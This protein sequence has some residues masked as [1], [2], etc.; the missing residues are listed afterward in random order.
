MTGAE[1]PT[2]PSSSGATGARPRRRDLVGA[3]LAGA[4]VVLLL[5]SEAALALPGENDPDS[6]VASFY[7]QHRS[8]VVVLQL[9][10]LVA[11]ALLAGYSARLRRF[12]TVAGTVGLITA[13]LACAP[14]VVTLVIALVADPAHPG[15]AGTW[16]TREPRGDD[17]LFVGITLF[18]AAVAARPRFP[19][20]AR[21]LGAIVAVLCGARLLLEWTGHPRGTFESLGPIAFVVLVACLGG[22]SATGRLAPTAS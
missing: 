19:A 9:I 22:F 2:A 14:A 17:L 18:G 21:V 7:Q 4:F 10:G 15:A 12:D 11:A 1:T 3:A 16:N 13:A 8:V 5:A 6:V 20:L